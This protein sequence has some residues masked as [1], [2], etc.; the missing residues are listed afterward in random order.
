MQASA[1]SGSHRGR[2]A[3]CYTCYRLISLI[4]LWHL[5]TGILCRFPEGKTAP[6][7]LGV[8][9]LEAWPWVAAQPGG[10]PPKRVDGAAQSAGEALTC[11]HPEEGL[12]SPPVLL[13]GT[14]A[15]Q[16]AES[17]VPS[18][19]GHLL[20]TRCSHIPHLPSAKVLVFI[21]KPAFC[22]NCTHCS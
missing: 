5:A 15:H 11:L 22:P 4:T 2:P 10:H 20:S 13:P 16:N 21:S 14:L 1:G 9:P 3:R 12:S 8:R 17:Q 18:L 6:K 19:G 7:M